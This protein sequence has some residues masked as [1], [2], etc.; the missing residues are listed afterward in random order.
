[1]IKTELKNTN[2]NQ[3][4]YHTLDEGEQYQALQAALQK[5]SDADRDNIERMASE[6]V[7]TVKAKC[8]NTQFSR[9]SALMLLSRIGAVWNG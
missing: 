5:L 2:E 1:M 4:M 8:P 9:N 6:L 7:D 3:V